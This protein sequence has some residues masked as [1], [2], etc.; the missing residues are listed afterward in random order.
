ML[1]GQS[2]NSACMRVH[3]G[4]SLAALRL[5]AAVFC[6]NYF[7]CPSSARLQRSN[8]KRGESGRLEHDRLMP[9][10]L[11]LTNGPRTLQP[12]EDSFLAL[13]SHRRRRRAREF[14]VNITREREAGDVS[15][16][17]Q[18]EILKINQLLPDRDENKTL[19]SRMHSSS[20]DIVR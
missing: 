1:N 15:E 4:L 10:S 14:C 19:L 6:F 12:S 8:F 7:S 16:N 2:D 5:L 20:L 9:K 18:Q 11:W 17:T 13:I 3:I